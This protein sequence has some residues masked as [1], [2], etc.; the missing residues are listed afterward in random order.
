MFNYAVRRLALGVPVLFVVTIL[1]F[2]MRVVLPGDPVEL[3]FFGEMPPPE[4]IAQVRHEW[5]L[6]RPVWE[7]YLVFME[8]AIRGD[9]GNSYRSQ[10]AVTEQI[11]ERYPNTIRLATAGLL[12]ASA[13]GLLAGVIAAVKQNSVFDVASMLIA[14]AGVSTP[15]FWLGLLL[16]HYFAVRWRIFPTMGSGTWQHLVLP[17]ITL[18]ML[19]ASVIARMVRSSMLEVLRQDYIRTARAKGLSER[20]VIYQH[21]LRNALVPIVTLMGL[22]FG[23]LLGGAFIIETVF[24]YHGVGHL[25]VTA[26]NTRDFP[27]IQGIM[28]V[29]SITYVAVNVIIDMTYALL[30][31]RIRYS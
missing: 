9:L 29:M 3:M 5:G 8:R 27:V 16:I 15:S 25:C 4:V 23:N 20:A 12:V 19:S 31:P 2:L 6:D 26:I 28:L 17:A 22:Q 18:G 1:V 24:A 11:M 30:N 10:V 7:Q 13:I 14:L 21:A